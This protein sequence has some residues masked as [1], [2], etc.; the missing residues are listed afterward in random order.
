MGLAINKIRLSDHSLNLTIS[1]KKRRNKEQ[2]ILTTNSFEDA[3]KSL[4]M[5]I[6]MELNNDNLRQK[7]MY[8]VKGKE[9][10]NPKLRP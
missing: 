4:V 5:A 6:A 3:K 1:M 10:G 2:H 7:T 8:I 9:N